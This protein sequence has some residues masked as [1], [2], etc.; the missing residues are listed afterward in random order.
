MEYIIIGV[1]CFAAGVGLGILIMRNNYKK[2]RET[3][4]IVKKAI[5]SKIFDAKDLVRLVREQLNL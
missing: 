3:E 4:Q 2:Y 5:E 1:L